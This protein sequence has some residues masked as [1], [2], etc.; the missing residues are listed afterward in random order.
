MSFSEI[1][2][3][4]SA[5]WPLVLLLMI[6]P[7]W[8]LQKYQEI[9]HQKK[10]QLE[11]WKQN[12]ISAIEKLRSS[13]TFK[14]QIE[15]MTRNISNVISNGFSKKFIPDSAGNY[16]SNAFLRCFPASH[17]IKGTQIYAFIK[18]NNSKCKAIKGGMLE[19]KKTFFLA[20]IMNDLL[21]AEKIPMSQ[22]KMLN[23][24]S[25]DLFGDLITF[26]YLAFQGKGKLTPSFYNKQKCFIIWNDFRINSEQKGGYLLIFPDTAKVNSNPLKYAI[27][28]YLKKSYPNFNPFLV[29]LE[30]VQESGKPLIWAPGKTIPYEVAKLFRKEIAKTESTN[31]SDREKLCV[32]G[33]VSEKVPGWWA[34]RNTIRPEIPYEIWL[35]SKVPENLKFIFPN[36]VDIALVAI[37]LF[38]WFFLN[39]SFS[40]KLWFIVY[41][42]L[43]GALPLGFLYMFSS[44]VIKMSTDREVKESIQKTISHFEKID[45]ESLS[46]QSEFSNLCKQAI[47]SPKFTNAVKVCP[48]I[49][50]T[51]GPELKRVFSYFKKVGFPLQH[52]IAYRFRNDILIITESGNVTKQ[53]ITASEFTFLLVSGVKKY[54]NPDIKDNQ[55]FKDL[56]DKYLMFFKFFTSSFSDSIFPDFF[57]LRHRIHLQEISESSSFHF[58]DYI[59]ES[60]SLE[61]CLMMRSNADIPLHQYLNNRISEIENESLN[62]RKIDS[63]L[64]TINYSFGRIRNGVFTPFQKISNNFM[65][66]REG[67]KFISEMK[68]GCEF[69]SRR[70]LLENQ[71]AII[72]YPLKKIPGFVL[73]AQIS[74]API[75]LSRT[76]KEIILS[77][78]IALAGLTISFFAFTVV[79]HLLNPLGQINMALSKVSR[80]DL[81]QKLKFERDDEIGEAGKAFNS[82]IDGLVVR[83]NLGKF[84]SQS[85]E[86]KLMQMENTADQSQNSFQ[87]IEA[88]ILVSDIR[89]FTTIS[90]KYPPEDVV[91]MLNEHLEGMTGA[92][93]TN[94]GEIDQFIGDAVVALFNPKTCTNPVSCALNAAVA[95]MKKHSEIQIKRMNENKFRYAM[96]IG[97]DSGK[98]F[99]V[100]F[101]SE[102]RM[103]H[104]II[105]DPR[106][107]AEKLEG[108]S[109]LGVHSKI[110]VSENVQI[111][112][113]DKNFNKLPDNEAWEVVL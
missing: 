81:S 50:K 98:I 106:I 33:Q 22:Y 7:V 79:R 51:L 107:K 1:K 100:S 101:G 77:F 87:E 69:N 24:R 14:D 113:K 21:D 6:I 34:T 61:I 5:F 36:P 41:F 63:D 58:F 96:G 23:K 66:S 30:Y 103:E 32:P 82:M 86:G 95:M 52:I 9:S 72:A 92:I 104:N 70:I 16:I 57:D 28:N 11:F 71:K 109:K 19:D 78:F 43:A 74:F 4:W 94:S 39:V 25:T 83:R 38:G 88:A 2:R 15:E 47:F 73:G 60:N 3:I 12:T 31:N 54:F 89:D 53:D 99:L 13:A 64:P 93:Q 29:S 75:H 26:D 56:A 17:R 20:N 84:V 40:M 8:R 37:I 105:G 68:K 27:L 49:T 48:A 111:Q 45:M 35:V 91:E 80:G 46:V 110:I 90:E 76:R 42:T 67:Q 97:I 44:T 102:A 65:R 59:S 18:T 112:L 10:I 85:L 108:L 55:L 62:I